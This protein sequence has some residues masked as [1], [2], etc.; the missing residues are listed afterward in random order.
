ML[1]VEFLTFFTV[2]QRGDIIKKDIKNV[3]CYGRKTYN[4]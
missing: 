1:Q 4:K 2:W 3:K